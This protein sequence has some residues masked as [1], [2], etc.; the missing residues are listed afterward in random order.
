MLKFPATIAGILLFMGVSNAAPPPQ[1]L[2]EAQGGEAA[3][4]ALYK[5][6]VET[7]SK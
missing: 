4:R 6:L 5:E 2:A 7:V 1:S 3:F